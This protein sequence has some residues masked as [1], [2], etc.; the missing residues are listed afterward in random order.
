MG[1]QKAER[2]GVMEE[3]GDLK[4]TKREQAMSMM[5][6]RGMSQLDTARAFLIARQE[7]KKMEVEATEKAFLYMLAIPLNVLVAD[8]VITHD[9]APEYVRSVMSLYES[10]EKGIVTDQEL[11]DLLHEYSG[12]NIEADWLEHNCGEF[13]DDDVTIVGG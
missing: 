6:K 12:V 7:A 5:R 9:N 3:G 4:R 1:L 10:V 13:K 11:A 8:G 2:N